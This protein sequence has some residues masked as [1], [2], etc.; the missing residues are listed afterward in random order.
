MAKADHLVKHRFQPGGPPGPGRPR[1]A[2]SRLQEFVLSMLEADF[3]Q[4]GADTIARVRE[5][6]PQ[7]YLTACVSLLPKQQ[8]NVES[9]FADISDAELD[10]LEQHLAMLRARTIKRLEKF[11]VKQ[12]DEETAGSSPVDD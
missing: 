5:K 9:P 1:G 8:Q 3:K 6:F 4:H 7:V 12:T 2:R 10:E 11:N